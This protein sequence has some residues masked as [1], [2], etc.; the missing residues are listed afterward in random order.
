ME[1]LDIILLSAVVSVLF[2]VFII[3]TYREFSVMGKSE[4]KGGKEKG[5]RAEMVQF[6]QKIFTDETI[7]PDK[8]KELLSIII[9]NFDKMDSGEKSDAIS[10]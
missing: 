10:K 2:L 3:A 8:K 4:F 6:L 5:P 9:K 7:E 1:N